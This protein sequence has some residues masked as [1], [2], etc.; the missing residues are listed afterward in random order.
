[1]KKRINIAILVMVMVIGMFSSVYATGETDS[2][3]VRTGVLSNGWTYTI[4]S[5]TPEEIAAYEDGSNDNG[6]MLRSSEWTGNVTVPI[7]NSSGT[8]G[9]NLGGSFY[10]SPDNNVYIDVVS[11]PNSMPSVNLGV[12][13]ASGMGLD[14]IPNV[15]VNEQV[16]LHIG[17]F[18][19]SLTQ[20][21]VSTY[22]TVSATGRF[23]LFTY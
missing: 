4:R 19:E 9:A 22:E 20:V 8:N 18:T 15:R 23:H 3:D 16:M 11:L 5:L 2:K 10:T 12:G 17:S 14:W 21:K 7:A 13:L 1:M 6:G